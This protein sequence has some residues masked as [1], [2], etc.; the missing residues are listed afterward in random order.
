MKILRFIIYVLIILMATPFLLVHYGPPGVATTSKVALHALVGYGGDE[1]DADLV[2]QQLHVADGFRLNLYASGLGK[3]RFL[4]TT[5]AGDILLSRPRTGDVLMLTRD[6][7]QDG[8]PD[9]VRVLLSGLTRPHGMDILDG[10]LYIAESNAVGKIGFNVESGEVNGDYI[11]IIEGLGDKGNHWTKTLRAGPDGW[12][13]LSSGSTCNVCEEDDPQ[14]ATIMRFKPDG[15][16]LSVYA[17]GLRNSVGMDW[18]PWSNELFATDNGRDLLGDDFPP[19]ELNNIVAGGFYGWPYINASTPDPD[20]GAKLPSDATAN[21]PPTFE[22]NA[23]NA[24]LGITFLEH[25]KRAGFDRSALVAL[26]GSWNRSIP[27]GYKVVVL[28]WQTDGTVTERDFVTGFLQG[29]KLLG[30][31]VDVAEA[32]DGSIY[33]SDDYSGSV[34]R[35]DVA[36]DSQ[37]SVSLPNP[38]PQ[39]VAS[40]DVLGAYNSAEL[41]SVSAQGKQLYDQFNCFSCHEQKIGKP[42]IN[43]HESYNVASLADFFSAP[44]PPMPAFPLNADEREALA[45]YLFDHELNN[46]Q[47]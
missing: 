26:H 15:S 4:R 13:Y 24:P 23:H 27:D 31:P 40:V 10:W 3:I 43:L 19:C 36:D 7:N 8:F 41:R 18:A 35:V 45:V 14:R 6:A 33:I 2:R 30:R 25:S 16:E 29:G 32:S 22:F 37:S 42:L 5:E 28:D 39:L 44:T 47:K 9:D 34:Y 20:F 38:V 46:N 12:M 1:P 11:R 21:R 17:T